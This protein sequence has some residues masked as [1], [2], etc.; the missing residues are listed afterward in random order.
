MTIGWNSAENTADD[1]VS[2][3]CI[4]IR[5][6]SDGDKTVGA[7]CGEPYSR[8]VI[9]NDGRY[10]SYDPTNPQHEGKRPAFRVALNFFVLA[11]RRMKIIEGG[12][13]W[14][15]D[16]KKVRGKYG[17]DEWLFEIE[18]HGEGK[19][20]TYSILPET[21]IDDQ[22]QAMIAAEELFDLEQFY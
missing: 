8:K 14:F 5:L 15:R 2:S 6:P 9:W 21:K 22:V 20:T 11:E 7:F 10:E 17:L 1:V 3:S 13:T 4:F 16:L 18:R 12:I 19:E